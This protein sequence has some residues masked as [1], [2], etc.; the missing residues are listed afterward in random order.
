MHKIEYIADLL[1]KNKVA[2]S[3]PII[4]D[5]SLD[6]TFFAFVSTQEPDGGKKP[7]SAYKLNQIAA[8]AEEHGIK[9]SFVV[10]DGG[11]H[12]LDRSVKTML[13]GKFP[14]RIRNSFTTANK[15]RT[16]IWVEPKKALP[17]QEILDVREAISE[18][19]GF[20]GIEKPSIHITQQENIPTSTAILRTLR[21][22]APC[23]LDVLATDLRSKGFAVP[24]EVWMQH[25]M[26]RLRK[27]GNV[28]RRQDGQ[29][30]LSLTALSALGTEKN[31]RSPDIKRALAL[32]KKG[33]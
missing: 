3:G 6:S 24:N 21:T 29:Y 18:F 15:S 1:S 16:E 30:F 10:V 8:T 2:R 31:R 11:D 17:D 14:D 19:L 5:H 33:T 20:L 27:A 25:A 22:L 13:F 12:D 4:E 7:T 26:E 28:V 32:G 9:L 23:S